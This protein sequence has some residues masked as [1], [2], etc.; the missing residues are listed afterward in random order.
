ML[1][2]VLLVGCVGQI[3]SSDHCLPYS[4]TREKKRCGR[5]RWEAVPVA[6]GVVWLYH[7]LG[8]LRLVLVVNE[9]LSSYSLG[10]NV[11][12]VERHWTS[13]SL[14][15]SWSWGPSFLAAF[16]SSGKKR[17][18][19]GKDFFLSK[20]DVEFS[21]GSLPEF[22]CSFMHLILS[23]MRGIECVSVHTLS[24]F[25][26]FLGNEI[27][28]FVKLFSKVTGEPWSGRQSWSEG[29]ICRM[30]F[31]LRVISWYLFP[32]RL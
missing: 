22:A 12:R 14:S 30:F 6:T 1:N 21:W 10:R 13:L 32:A 26:H 4:L 27:I 3:K 17:E 8:P 28:A 9:E 7:M 5:T 20:V 11:R 2:R 19:E 23:A 24:S 16:N 15:L 18:R 29:V 25:I 31:P